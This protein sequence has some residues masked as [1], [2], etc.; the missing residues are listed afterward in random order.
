ML[1]AIATV[2]LAATWA[3]G[4]VRDGQAARADKLEVARL[5]DKMTT[6]CIGRFLIDMP[7]EARLELARPRIDGFDISSFD[8]PEAGFKVRLGQREARLRSA[9]D[10]FGG[11][12]NLE[13]VR[14]VKTDNGVV[15]TIFVHSRTVAQ[16]TRNR[17]LE[18]ER[19]RY[20]GVAVEA[21]V[22]GQGM[23][24]DL[25]ADK[26]DPSLVEDLPKLVAKLVPNPS[27]KPPTEPGFCVTVPGFATR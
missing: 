1:A 20:E 5:T 7:E 13:S 22:H 19:Y 21:M 2:G 18:L 14:D 16:G 24:F 8:E 25:S 3:V 10:Q 17:G 12:R 15:G 6:V 26:Y 11:N 4:Q 9:P 27:N 23:S